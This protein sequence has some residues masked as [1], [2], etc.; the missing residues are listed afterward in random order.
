MKR[1]RG[2]NEMLNEFFCRFTGHKSFSGDKGV[3]IYQRDGRRFVVISG[4]RLYACKACNAIFLKKQK[5]GSVVQYLNL[6]H[7]YGSPEAKEVIA[8][9][10]K[11]MSDEQFVRRIAT[12][13]WCWNKR[14]VIEE[15]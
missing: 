1:N 5:Q 13:N 14:K 10:A 6:L 3:K 4:Y 2:S 8:Y 12:I 9:V 15:I 11:Y 7:K